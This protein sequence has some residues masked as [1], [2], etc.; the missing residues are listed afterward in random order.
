MFKLENS[1][2]CVEIIDPAS[3]R[4]LL[5]SRYCAGGYV[6]QVKDKKKGDLL[7]GPTYPDAGF[8]PF[9][10][11]GAPEVFLTALNQESADVAD[12]V[13][14]L[15]AG[16]VKRTSP[17][18][19]FHV[20]DNPKVM[21]FARWEVEQSA[22]KITMN[23]KQIFEKWDISISRSVSLKG[24]I[25]ISHTTL[26]NNGI[27]VC[28]LRWFPHPFFP[29]PQNGIACRFLFPVAVPENPG[30]FLNSQG[31]VEMKPEY[32]WKKGLYQP[33]IVEKPAPFSAELFHPLVKKVSVRCDYAPSFLPLWANDR[34]FSFEPYL[35][36]EIIGGEELSWKI[37][38]C[39][40]SG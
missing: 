4:S 22:G 31:F 36:K 39:F 26:M 7:A 6:F 14:V 24:Q 32:E 18:T 29:I 15:G 10:G 2:L 19:P 8:N 11:R 37:E 28:P 13:C 40:G 1:F 20:R 9:D 21:E 25:I 3:D 27:A 33:L 34:T 30:Y 38:Y 5:G 12:N 23:T 16:L 17:K 35:E